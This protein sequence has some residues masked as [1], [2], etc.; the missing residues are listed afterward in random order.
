M[1]RVLAIA[2][3][4]AIA[5]SCGRPDNRNHPTVGP[6]WRQFSTCLEAMATALIEHTHDHVEGGVGLEST[7]PPYLI[8]DVEQA[9][10]ELCLTG[11]E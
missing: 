3:I 4:T 10:M 2:L 7:S 5:L 9:I 8:R 1:K 6:E 11:D